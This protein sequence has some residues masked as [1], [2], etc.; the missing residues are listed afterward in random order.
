MPKGAVREQLP[1]AMSNNAKPIPGIA[2]SP[3]LLIPANI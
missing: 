2:F 1:S 3:S